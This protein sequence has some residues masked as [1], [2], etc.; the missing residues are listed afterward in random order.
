MRVRLDTRR[1]FFLERVVSHWDRQPRKVTESPSLE[2]FK[3]R[4]DVVIRTQFSG[5]Y[6][7]KWMA[8]LGS[9]RDLF[10]Q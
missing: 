4:V 5:K 10:Q 9:L 6:G 3:E 1:N 8:R 7:G 2:V